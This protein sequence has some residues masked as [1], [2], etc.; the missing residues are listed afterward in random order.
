[1]KI[2][3]LALALLGS[4]TAVGAPKIGVMPKIMGIDYSNAMG[5]GAAAAGK[6]LGVELVFDGPVTN[7]P[8]KQAALIETW[9]AQKFD[10]ICVAPNDPDAIGP[11]LRKARARGIKVLTY[12]ADAQPRSRDLFVNQASPAAIGKAL[13]DSMVRNVGPEARYLIITGSLTAANQNLWMAEMEK[14]RQ[15]A[16]PK[17]VN[18]SPV[19]KAAEEDSARATQV[20]IDVLKAYPDVQG[21]FAITSEALPGAAEGLIKAHAAGRVFLTGLSTPKSMSSYVKSGACGEVILWNP[22][23]LGY[24]TVQ[25]AVQLVQ[26]KIAADTKEIS[27]GR[28]GQKQIVGQQVL[29]GE[30]LVF[31]KQNID[32]YGF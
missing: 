17:M 8:A 12:D 29:L 14:Y 32:Q 21:I 3:P 25:A 23:D 20:T 5:R 16:Y 6:E 1:M 30:P 15:A 19:P 9:I 10:A 11:A 2:L 26:G 22:E 7:D 31:T 24:L 28:L 27:A 18:L 4:L 13:I